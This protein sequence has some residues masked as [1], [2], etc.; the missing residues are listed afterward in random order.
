MRS[1]E[2]GLDSITYDKNDWKK[3]IF[4]VMLFVLTV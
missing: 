1:F 4:I 3:I 2:L